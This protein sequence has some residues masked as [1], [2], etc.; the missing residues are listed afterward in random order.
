MATT[1]KMTQTLD[2]KTKTEINTEVTYK[3]DNPNT[4]TTMA[5]INSVWAHILG[6]SSY[7]GDEYI[8]DCLIEDS[9]GNKITAVV[10][11]QLTETTVRKTDIE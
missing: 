3:L 2:V 11:A 6:D 8:D 9:K 5:Q 1:Y 7:T 10:S 4:D